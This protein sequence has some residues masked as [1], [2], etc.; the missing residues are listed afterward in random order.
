MPPPAPPPKSSACLR[1]LEPLAFGIAAAIITY[2]LFIPPI[3]GL[4]DDG[5]FWKIMGQVGLRYPT[6]DV[7][8][9]AYGHLTVEYDITQPLWASGYL[10]SEIPFVAGAR[11]IEKSGLRRRVLDI[12]TLGILHSLVFCAGVALVL[13][14]GRTWRCPARIAYTFLVVFFFTDVGYVAYFNSLYSA[15]ASYLFLLLLAG[16]VLCLAGGRRLPVL[17]VAFWAAAL[18]LV[19]SKP[20][21]A[22]LAPLLGLLGYVMTCLGRGPGRPKSAIVLAIALCA[23]GALYY[24]RIP[25]YLKAEALY[26]DVFFELLLRSPD[27]TADLKE[28]GLPDDWIRYSGTHAYLPGVPLTDPVFRRDFA[29]LVGYPK[30]LGFYLRHP[31]RLGLLLKLSSQGA[32]RLR[33]SYLGNFP[34]RA[35]KEPRALSRAF[36]VWSAAKERLGPSGPWLLP[37]LWVANLVGSFI[38]FRSSKDAEK[39]CLAVAVAVLVASSVVE[40]LVCSLA[41]ALADVARHLHSFNAMTDLLLIADV[42]FLV[43]VTATAVRSQTRTAAAASG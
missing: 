28:L 18:G 9:R 40:F 25:E 38:F 8:T 26:N 5:D 11:F 29:R 39:R 20:Q 32:F 3:V 13:I 10:T 1:F 6:G 17:M 12:R 43:S 34:V 37:F 2:Q 14:A 30:I 21:E 35:G 24:S 4:A 31:S 23:A 42:V 19:T 27:P 22:A 16:M 7:Q 33:Q 15:T 41:D 36:G